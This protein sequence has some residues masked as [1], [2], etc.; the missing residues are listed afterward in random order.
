MQKILAKFPYLRILPLLIALPLTF[1]LW[2]AGGVD[3]ILG[4]LHPA[5]KL[6]AVHVGTPAPLFHAPS[7]ETWS[8]KEFE[9]SSL[10]GHAVVIHFWATWCA[11]CLQELPHLVNLARAKKEIIFLTVAV[12]DTRASLEIF[13][14]QHPELQTLATDT[15]LLID[16][17]AKISSAYGSLQYPETFLLNGDMM[18]DN[19]FIGPQAWTDPAMEPYLRGIA[20]TGAERAK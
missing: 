9:L 20:T 15:L 19:K 4:F 16:T 8:G 7:A 18:I 17:E 14:K 2:E 10:K 13:F 12:N 5:E 6:Q 3:K 11:P 1:Y